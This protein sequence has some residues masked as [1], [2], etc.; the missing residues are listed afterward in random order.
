MDHLAMLHVYYPDDGHMVDT[1]IYDLLR[2]PLYAAVLR[3]SAGM[4]LIRANWY[5][6]FVT[7]VLI[8]FF[9]GWI[10][11]VEEK[12][13]IARYPDYAQYRRRVPAFAPGVR[14]VGRF[15]HCLLRGE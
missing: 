9:V 15:L 10:T 5:A 11:L 1:G 12:E 6:L 2:H 13:L 7:I 4:A 8:F 3:I 14:D